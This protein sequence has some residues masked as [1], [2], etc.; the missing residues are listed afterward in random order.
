M[1]TLVPL[2]SDIPLDVL[3]IRILTTAFVVMT[4]SWAVGIFGPIIGGALAGLP[5]ILGPGFYFLAKQ[6]PAAFVAQA[7]SYALLSLCATQFFLLAYITTAGTLRP[8]IALACAIGTW[9][10]VALLLQLLPAWP[11]VG[12]VGFIVATSIC[13]RLGQ[14]FVMDG[15]P[16]KGR[17]GFGLLAVRGSLAGALVA[18]VTTAS[19]WLG[20][21]GAGLLLAFPIGYTV[22]A[23]TIHHTFG[24]ASVVA[25]LY[26]ALLGTAS[27]AGFCIALT[28][29]I[30]HWT[31]SIALGIALATSVII[32]LALI[33]RRRLL[34]ISLDRK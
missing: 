15:S 11:I 17:A 19:H 2:L 21:T 3:T 9:M 16:T 32:T 26:S 1:T 7:A 14:R 22:V 29:A 24:S 34:A 5:I 25:T 12:A 8:W 13:L 27:L 10:F 33:L 20:S 30:P 23:V 4:I 18:A 31:P 28:I 6:A